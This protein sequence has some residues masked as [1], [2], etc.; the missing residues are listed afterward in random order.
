MTE[1]QFDN[2]QYLNLGTFRKNG[3]RVETPVWF[4]EQDGCFFVL[5]NNQAGKVKRL[6]NS[7]RCEITPCTMTGT[8][9]GSWQASEAWLIEDARE[10][11]LAHQA[12]VNKYG[13]Q[14]RMLDAGAWLGGRIRQRSFIRI[15]KPV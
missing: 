14:M 7:A 4:A 1:G 8:P 5:S 12:L 10:I 6:R 13:W 15:R 9:T 11:Q 3:C 2:A